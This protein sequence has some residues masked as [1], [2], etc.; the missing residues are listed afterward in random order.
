[1]RTGASARRLAADDVDAE[2][3]ELLGVCAAEHQ[4]ADD[5]VPRATHAARLDDD[6][7]D[8]R[9]GAVVLEFTGACFAHRNRILNAIVV[10]DDRPE[11]A[12][13]PVAVVCASSS[14]LRD[15]RLNP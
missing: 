11:L 14:S 13:E 2:L 3:P 10:F 12:V 9:S 1:M 7:D 15:E 4:I 6:S 8:G 5:G